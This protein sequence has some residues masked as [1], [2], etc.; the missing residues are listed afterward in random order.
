MAPKG[1]LK[2]Y[3]RDLYELPPHILQQIDKDQHVQLRSSG[4]WDYVH[5]QWEEPDLERV[6]QFVLATKFGQIVDKIR[7]EGRPCQFDRPRVTELLG[8]SE[9]GHSIKTAPIFTKTMKIELFREKYQSTKRDRGWDLLKVSSPFTQWLQFINQQLFMASRL[10]I[11]TAESLAVGVVAW[12]GQCFD[13][14]QVVYQNMKLELALK[15]A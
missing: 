10:D 15:K 9:G 5:R 4:L 11:A 7:V 2:V 1:K 13:W 12:R 3:A 8:C 6:R 14:G